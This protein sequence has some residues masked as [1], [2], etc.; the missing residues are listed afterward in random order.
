MEPKNQAPISS[1]AQQV[2]TNFDFGISLLKALALDQ[3]NSA[4]SVVWSPFS[5]QCGFSLLNLGARNKTAEEIAKIFGRGKNFIWLKGL[6]KSH[7]P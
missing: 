6:L 4:S 7:D 3:N 1:D 5:V 2:E